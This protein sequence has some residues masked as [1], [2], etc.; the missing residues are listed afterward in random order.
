MIGREYVGYKG[1][2]ERSGRARFTGQG[3]AVSAVGGLQPEA[4]SRPRYDHAAWSVLVLRLAR[5]VSGPAPREAPSNGP[6]PTHDCSSRRLVVAQ[7][8]DT[9]FG[10]SVHGRDEIAWYIRN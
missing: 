8:K 10:P 5:L 6:C 3:L 4:L 7:R 1:V 9:L 2:S